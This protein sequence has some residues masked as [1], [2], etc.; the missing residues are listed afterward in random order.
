MIGRGLVNNN[1]L[2]ERDLKSF[3]ESVGDSRLSVRVTDKQKVANQF[4]ENCKIFKPE[5]G[6]HFFIR[7]ETD[8]G[9]RGEFIEINP[10][11]NGA[12]I[13]QR[14]KFG[15]NNKIIEAASLTKDSESW[16][17]KSKRFKVEIKLMN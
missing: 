9:M 2:A 11:N 12:G 15:D 17:Y 10:A 16:I 14:D 8:L 1:D 7:I 4:I 6:F 13:I 3:V 5:D